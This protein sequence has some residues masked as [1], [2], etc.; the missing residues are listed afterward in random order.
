MPKD[1]PRS[2]KE[3]N[4][5]IQR[6]DSVQDG[7]LTKALLAT[8]TALG[9]SIWFTTKGMF[10]KA[11]EAGTAD[12]V[13]MGNALIAAGAAG[14]LISTGTML[15]MGVAA[16]AN[17]R[18]R[19]PVLGLAVSM[20]PFMLGISTSNAILGTA[21]P[22]SLVYEMRDHA[23]AYREYYYQT[24]TDAARSQSAVQTLV[25]IGSSTCYLAEQE[26]ESGILTG[27]PGRGATYAAYMSACRNIGEITRT[28]N[29][30][31]ERTAERS[32]AAEGLLAELQAIPN[33]TT[34][35]VF[36]RQAAF[37]DA[38]REVEAMAAGANAERV[39]ARLGPQ[40][41][42]LEASI[43]GLGTSGGALGQRQATANA[44]LRD[45]LGT[46][47]DTVL[48]FVSG[49]SDEPPTA[50]GALSYMGAAVAA[51]W[52]RNIPQILLAVLTD[53]MPGW[54]LGLLMVSRG[55]QESRR[56]ELIEQAKR[57]SR[58]SR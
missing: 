23:E 26:G 39:S 15:C 51:Y 25:P 38:A 29:E 48:A 37:R 18:Q 44:N 12:A 57:A 41:E 54:F 36:E 22:P 11:I 7:R 34:L 4:N 28:L 47:R 30:T 10:D 52:H 5:E 27:S 46:V 50:P 8:T 55:T 9:G 14:V 43:A 3:I 19:L 58:P 56:R 2:I 20:L 6:L 35:S 16:E 21:G 13:G 31:V 33:N 53:L 42:I 49:G 45:T 40:L 17:R 24:E 1:T 32:A